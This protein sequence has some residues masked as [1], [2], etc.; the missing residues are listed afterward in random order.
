MRIDGLGFDVVVPS[1]WDVQITSRLPT[2]DDASDQPVLHAANFPLPN[3]R[4]DFGSGAVEIMSSA[5]VFISLLEY[6]PSEADKA[7]F[8]KKGMPRRLELGEFRANGLQ[9]TIPGQSGYQK[10][11]NHGGRAFCLYIVFGDHNRRA[12]LIPVAEDLLAGIRLSSL[13]PEDLL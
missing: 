3:G 1:G 8:A 10:F 7:L 13:W 12:E 9:R 2:E 6:D 4:G 5:H 11:F